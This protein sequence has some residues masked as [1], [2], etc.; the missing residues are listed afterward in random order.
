M[1][2]AY[3]FGPFE[4]RPTSRDL[5]VEG[6][7]APLGARAFD[8]LLA[9]VERRDRLVTKDELL[10]VAWPGLVVEENNLQ[11]QIS[12]LRKILGDG[13]IKTVS[14]KGYR[15]TAEISGAEAPSIAAVS[16]PAPSIAVLPFVNR[17]HDPEDEYFSDGLADELL[18]VLAK[19][20]GLRVAARSSAFTFKGKNATVAEIGRVLNVAT[21]L[22]GSVRKVGNRLRI[23]VQLVKV[24]D[25]YH[26]W[27]ESYDRTL[28]DIFA[29]QDDIAQ[30]AVKELRATLLGEAADATAEKA[31]TEAVAAAAKGRSTDP[32]AYRLLLQAR[33]FGDRGTREDT[34]KSIGYLKDALARDPE[35]AIGWA[36]LAATYTREA[37]RRW[38]PV[39]EGYGLAREAVTRA[40]T[41]EPE[42]PEG[43]VV[44]GWIQMHHDWDSRGAEASCRR[45][46]ALAPG[47]ILVLRRAAAVIS[48][49][50]QLN[51][52][53]ELCQRALAQDPLSAVVYGN[54]ATYLYRSGRLTEA[55]AA[56]RKAL[57]LAPRRV[58]V[59][60]GLAQSLLA[61]G[62]GEEAL[63]EAQQEPQE[64]LRLRLRAIIHEAAG[65]HA[66]SEAALQ[67]LI[68][69]HEEDAAYQIAEV[70]AARREVDLAFAWLERAYVQRD[71]GLTVMKTNPLLR[72]LHADLRWGAILQKMRLVD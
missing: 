42:L 2:A 27:S 14:G 10:A 26:L 36:E 50:G 45:A 7:A 72:A 21:V 56:S 49:L 37:D 9:L 69:K 64:Q 39:V 54:L 44:L 17:S 48:R 52:A 32:E 20:H 68:A 46:L 1:P 59:H 63:A 22:E 23:S 70:Y 8:V 35:F 33:Y 4:L 41:L 71:P 16:R 19:I 61:Q 58:L 13:V 5:L 65:R 67:E 60:A 62:R 40:L 53:I 34:A 6:R 3:R 31:A 30:S 25:G 55:E 12:A 43:H 18:N 47:S 29:V 24:S 15:F 57:D 51:E 28:E 11:V 38:V 66:E